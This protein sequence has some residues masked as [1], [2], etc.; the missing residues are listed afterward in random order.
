MHTHLPFSPLPPRRFLNGLYHGQGTL[1]DS[2]EGGA[3]SASYSG[4]WEAGV[5]HGTGEARMRDGSVYCG[6]WRCGKYEGR[7]KLTHLPTG[8]WYDGEWKDGVR[9]GQG[10]DTVPTCN[11]SLD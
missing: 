1:I 7:G 4:M 9:H 8:A 2:R 11:Y 10:G 6:E 3:A 5:M